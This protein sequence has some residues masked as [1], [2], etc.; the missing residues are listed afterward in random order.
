M[1]A[2]SKGLHLRK[3][4]LRKIAQQ[5]EYYTGADLKAILYSAQLQAVHE[6]LG[7]QGTYSEAS[8]TSKSEEETQPESQAKVMVFQFSSGCTQ[9]QATSDM[10]QRVNTCMH[11]CSCIT[12]QHKPYCVLCRLLTLTHYEYI[13]L[14]AET[15][16]QIMREKTGEAT[17][18]QSGHVSWCFCLH[19]AT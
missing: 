12:Y 5:T 14:Q 15:L 2:L 19:S 11:D 6:I 13:L 7:D 3:A 4:D 1:K 16:R 8:D 17:L 18:Q 9:K 10:E